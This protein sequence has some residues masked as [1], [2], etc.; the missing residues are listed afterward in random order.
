MKRG[1]LIQLGANFSVAKC[2]KANDHKRWARIH[3]MGDKENDKVVSPE[4]VFKH[5]N[6]Y[7]PKTC[8]FIYKVRK[9]EK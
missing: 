4:S 5:H 7:T 6:L 9:L 1:C 3:N 8:R 2:Y